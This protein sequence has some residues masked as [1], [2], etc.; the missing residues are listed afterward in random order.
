MRRVWLLFSDLL[1]QYTL[2]SAVAFL[3]VAFALASALAAITEQDVM[4][5]VEDEALALANGPLAVFFTPADFEAVPDAARQREIGGFVQRTIVSPAVARIKVWDRSGR[6]L[7]SND[8]SQVGQQFP[9]KN[10]L[11]QALSGGVASEISVPMAAENERER[12]LGTLIEVY[13]PVRFA[14]QE[15]PRG[16]FEIYRYYAP[17]AERINA[18]RGA[19]YL[20]L[21]VAFAALYVALLALVWNAWRTIKRQRQVIEKRANELRAL[22]SLLEQ[23]LN[24]VVRDIQNVVEEAAHKPMEGPQETVKREYANLVTSLQVLLHSRKF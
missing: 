23:R 11:A 3:V 6:V 8:S 13:V 21:A 1:F 12:S 15:Q 20:G 17:V 9:I 22:N 5:D 24:L 14:P 2:I 16:S 10:E 19:V 18:L 4:R 7:Y